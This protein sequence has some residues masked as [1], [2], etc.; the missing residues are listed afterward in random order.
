MRVFQ[1]WRKCKGSDWS[2]HD[3]R[4]WGSRDAEEGRC[5]HRTNFRKHGYPILL[6][7][8]IFLSFLFSFLLF[9]MWEPYS[10]PFLC[11]FLH[12]LGIT[13]KP[14]LAQIVIEWIWYWLDWGFPNPTATLPPPYRKFHIAQ[15]RTQILATPWFLQRTGTQEYQVSFRRPYPTM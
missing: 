11:V 5:T 7:F 15:S 1:R 9:H 2:A 13:R 6:W 3:R 10:L 8:L 12:F 4:R 14:L